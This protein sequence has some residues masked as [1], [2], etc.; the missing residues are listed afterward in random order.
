MPRY[1]NLGGDSGVVA[2]ELGA[3][4]ITVEFR[5]GS[6]YLYNSGSAGSANVAHMRALAQAGKGLNGFITRVVRNGYASKLR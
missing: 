1:M 4:S 5:D 6:R 3:D 2:Y